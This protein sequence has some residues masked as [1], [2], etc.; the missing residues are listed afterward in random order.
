MVTKV[1]KINPDNFKKEEL[2]LKQSNVSWHLIEQ[3]LSTK[4]KN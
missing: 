3:I 1:Q 2:D 4:C